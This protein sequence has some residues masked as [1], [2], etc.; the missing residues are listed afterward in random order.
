MLDH[1]IAKLDQLEIKGDTISEDTMIDINK[2]FSIFAQRKTN[3]LELLK[4]FNKDL[5]KELTEIELPEL[6]KLLASK[7]ATV[8][9]STFKC[10]DCGREFKNAKGLGAHK[11]YCPQAKKSN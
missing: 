3:A 5:T 7:F 11:K 6:S 10:S 8:D 4:R 1:L 2:E 9:I